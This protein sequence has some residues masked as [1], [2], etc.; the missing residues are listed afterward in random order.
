MFVQELNWIIINNLREV[1]NKVL[2]CMPSAITLYVR[3]ILK[4]KKIAILAGTPSCRENPLPILY[5]FK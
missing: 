3:W 5:I 1:N 4:K 2:L